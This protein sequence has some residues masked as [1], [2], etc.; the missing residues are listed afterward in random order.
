MVIINKVFISKN[1]SF[2]SSSFSAS[3]LYN[4]FAFPLLLMAQLQDTADANIF[5]KVLSPK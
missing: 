3:A 2:S 4:V 1:Y 5:E